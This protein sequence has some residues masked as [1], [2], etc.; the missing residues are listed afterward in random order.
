MTHGRLRVALLCC[1]VVAACAAPPPGAESSL[2]AQAPEQA[3]SS[4]AKP[5]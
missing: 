3:T 1:A 5:G 4:Q 2:P